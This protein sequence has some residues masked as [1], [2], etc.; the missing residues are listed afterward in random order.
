MKIAVIGGGISG[1]RAAL[2]LGRAGHDVTLFEKQKFLGGRAFSFVT[3]E[4]G[5]IDIGQ[6]VWLKCCA[7]LEGL[8]RDLAIPDAL[9]YRQPSFAIHYKRP[10]RDDYL[11]QSAPLP[12]LLHLLPGLFRFPGLKT[13]ETL[14]L[15]RA[16]ASAKFMSG[17]V[18]EKLDGISFARWLGEHGQSAAAVAAMWEPLVLSVCNQRPAEVSARHALFTFRNSLLHSKHAADICMFRA[19][20]SEIFDRRA[21]AALR[22]AGVKLRLG[23]AV[24]PITPGAAVEIIAAAATPE[25]FDRALLT[26][27]V[28]ALA[29]LLPAEIRPPADPGRCAVAGL[30]LRYP[31]AV[32]DELFFAA[33]DSPVQWVFNKSA[34]WKQS[35]AD[36]S[37]LVE[38]VISGAERECAAGADAVQKELQPALERLLPRARG[39]TPA[40]VRFVSHAAATFAVPPGAEQGRHPV[41][42]PL[43]ENIFLA[44]DQAATG[45]PSTMES[46]ARAGSAAAIAILR[47]M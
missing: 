6:H 19:P 5:E 44:G 14:A 3:P 18:L 1:I 15:L 34:I 42:R 41:S 31:R 27:P 45:W 23:E 25:K 4:L 30:L 22:G 20:L 33:L 26:A 37:Q 17:A 36:G 9:V 21:Q 7:G 35:A 43:A 28:P 2:T 13:G 46:A 10:D 38:L 32:M 12:G 39:L 29:E 47:S 24:K 40:A 16:M 8:I 11:L